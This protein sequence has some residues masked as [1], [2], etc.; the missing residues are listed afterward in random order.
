[1]TGTGG[2]SAP[3]TL[4]LPTFVELETSTRCNRRC[5]WCP[6]GNV[7]PRTTQHLMP[8]SLIGKILDDLRHLGYCGE[9]SLQN[10]NE[11]LANERIVDE[12]RLARHRLSDV[13]L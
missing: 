13:S 3:N 9:L 7:V 10:F 11:P 8:M 12:F 6:T 1:M 5:A 4:E 2:E